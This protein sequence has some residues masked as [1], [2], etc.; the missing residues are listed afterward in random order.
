MTTSNLPSTTRTAAE[1][2][3]PGGGSA[4][5]VVLSNVSKRYG[6]RGVAASSDVTRLSRR[7]LMV[8]RR[9]R[10][11]SVFQSLNLIPR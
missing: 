6:R 2:P 7:K 10:A 11:G 4:D 5:A 3:E 1:L 8:T 9:E